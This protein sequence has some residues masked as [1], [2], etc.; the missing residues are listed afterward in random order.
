MAKLLAQV[1][2]GLLISC[3][4][5]LRSI[6]SPPEHTDFTLISVINIKT[7][8]ILQNARPS[9]AHAPLILFFLSIYLAALISLVE[10]VGM[11]SV[12][13]RG[14]FVAVASLGAEHGL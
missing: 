13:V 3:F 2:V 14:C 12:E 1:R 8:A 11:P 5:I 9:S 10:E 4:S 7:M 6:T